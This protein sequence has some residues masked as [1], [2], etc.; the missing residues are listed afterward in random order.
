MKP[1]TFSKIFQIA[2]GIIGFIAGIVI[3]QNGILTDWIQRAAAFV[4][5]TE[6]FEMN[7]PAVFGF[8]NL[9]TG[10]LLSVVSC[11]VV[12]NVFLKDWLEIRFQKYYWFLLSVILVFL[13][14]LG[15]LIVLNKTIQVDEIEHV[16]SAWYVVHGAIPYSDFFQHHNPLLWY[17]MTPFF[18]LGET[19]T[20]FFI[21]RGFMFL[22]ILAIAYTVYRIGR[23][24]GL[25]REWAVISVIL[26]LS[27]VIFIK[28]GIEIRPDSPYVLLG[29]ISCLYLIRFVK[30]FNQ[31]SLM[32]CGVTLGLSFLFIQ[33]SIILI[34]PFGLVLLIRYLIRKIPFQSLLVF[35]AAF[36]SPLLLFGI[37]LIATKSLNDYY[38]T[39]ILL[40]LN[41]LFSNQQNCLTMFIT[42]NP[43]HIVLL[44]F[45]LGHVIFHR[46]TLSWEQMIVILV[47]V[48][49][50][51]FPILVRRTAERNFLLG[52]PFLCVVAGYF[53]QSWLKHPKWNERRKLGIVML[54]VTLP[55][56]FLLKT[57]LIQHNRHQV[58]QIQYVLKNTAKTDRVYDG[59]NVFNLFR[60]D[61]HYFWY[62]VYGN[63]L[64]VRYNQITGGKYGDYDLSLLIQEKRPMIISN[65]GF[66]ISGSGLLST[67]QESPFKGLYIRRSMQPSNHS[68]NSFINILEGGKRSTGRGIR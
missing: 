24:T 5:S 48:L 58:R 23:E 42:Q 31:V 20:L 63:N 37:S 38:V 45:A 49:A 56:F 22:C 67:Y 1:K 47:A 11:Y 13:V 59:N 8:F 16:H 17:C 30:R 62:A 26:L 54:I 61:M 15:F 12:A 65:F 7:L 50:A 41:I 14:I 21:F 3:I 53:L 6:A 19:I 28:S 55:T 40:N 18:I 39:N 57:G 51:G 29:S 25:H 68:V 46:K 35:T 44:F 32:I 43:L 4:L 52:I 9:L 34:F 64:I 10:L 27:E 66:D 33:K 60:P 2:A 36:L